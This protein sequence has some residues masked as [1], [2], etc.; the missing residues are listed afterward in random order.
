MSNSASNSLATRNVQV[1]RAINSMI[2]FKQI[3]GRGTRVAEEY[4]K[5]HFTIMDFRNAT[6]NFADPDFDGE[7]VQIY[8]SKGDDGDVIPSD[9]DE[10]DAPNVDYDDPDPEAPDSSFPLGGD[11][12]GGGVGEPRVKY[13]VND[14]TF[15]VSK[16][17]IQYLDADGKLI[18]ESLR[19]YTRNKVKAEFAIRNQSRGCQRPW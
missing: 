18:T 3:I 6:D 12:E 15:S 4:G 2:E 11:G 16:E 9:P 13:V 14:V 7:P 5:T 1:D 19:D 10:E 8:E 17:Q